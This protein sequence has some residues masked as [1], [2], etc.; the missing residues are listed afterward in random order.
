MNG[1]RTDEIM[2]DFCQLPGI[3]RCG[4]YFHFAI[5]LPRVR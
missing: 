1:M 5:H 4:T 3:R 2:R